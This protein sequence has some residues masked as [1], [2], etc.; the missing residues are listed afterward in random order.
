MISVPLYLSF[1]SIQLYP[2]SKKKLSL[3]Y[4]AQT[5]TILGT[6]QE[7][8]AAAGSEWEMQES[9][10]VIFRVKLS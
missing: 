3:Q 8:A 7:D 5:G 1:F 6:P 9:L 10:H 4:L 2:P